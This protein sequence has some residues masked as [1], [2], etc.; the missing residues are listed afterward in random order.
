[1]YLL[2]IWFNLSD[3]ATEGAIYDSHAEKEKLDKVVISLYNEDAMPLNSGVGAVTCKKIFS[4][5]DLECIL[6]SGS[7]KENIV[8]CEPQQE[9]VYRFD[10]D[11]VQHGYRCG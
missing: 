3:P 6:T 2:Q 7:V 9:G 10:I 4:D 11:L 5:A 8:V 1:M